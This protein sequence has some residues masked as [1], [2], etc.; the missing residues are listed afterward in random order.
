[1]DA[2]LTQQI[3]DY[4]ATQPVLKAW[5]FGSYARG[6][7]RKD[8]D[9]DLL[10][11]FDRKNAKVGMFKYCAMILDL[12]NILHRGVDLVE[13][14]ALLPFAE[15]TANKDKKLIYERNRS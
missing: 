8:S 7:E 4:F 12:E 11:Q 15:R 14:G 3:S 9:I 13:E 2:I 6:E 1:M 5:V 10:V